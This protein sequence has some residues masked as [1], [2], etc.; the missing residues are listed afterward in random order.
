MSLQQEVSALT[1][2]GRGGVDGGGAAHHPRGHGAAAAVVW[3]GRPGEALSRQLLPL[4]V[5]HLLQLLA[6]LHL[7]L[8]LALLTHLL[9]EGRGRPAGDTSVPEPGAADEDRADFPSLSL[10]RHAEA[11]SSPLGQRLPPQ[12]THLGL[13]G[14]LWLGPEKMTGTHPQTLA[15]KSSLVGDRACSRGCSQDGWDTTHEQPLTSGGKGL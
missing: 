4:L 13:K 6:G 3:G 12:K 14:E 7:G 5:L 15:L 1:L 10:L 9:P 8:L 2:P 11:P